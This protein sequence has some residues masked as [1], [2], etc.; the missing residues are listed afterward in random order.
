MRPASNN[1]LTWFIISFCC[2]WLVRYGA[3]IGGELPGIISI[4]W[5][6]GLCGGKTFGRSSMNNDSY[7]LRKDHVFLFLL[8]SIPL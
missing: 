3:L 5:S 7:L 8:R 2:A 4:L 1:S 6:S